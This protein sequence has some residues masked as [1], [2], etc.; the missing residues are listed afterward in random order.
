MA[1]TV[2]SP[3]ACPTAQLA[4]S[5]AISVTAVQR[6]VRA[7]LPASTPA[8]VSVALYSTGD[9]TLASGTLSGASATPTGCVYVATLAAGG[10]P[11]AQ[12][13]LIDDDLWGPN[14]V[15]ARLDSLGGNVHVNVSG[16]PASTQT[17]LPPIACP[18]AQLATSGAISVTGVLRSVRVGLPAS[19]PAG[20]SVALYWTEDSAIA[21]GTLPNA[22][23]TPTG[24]V[25]IATLS[26][27]SN[28]HA[29]TMPLTDEQWGPNLVVV[30]LDALGGT[31]YL[32]VSG[33]PGATQTV[34]SPITAPTAQLATSAAISVTGVQS[35]VRVGLP[36]ATPAGVSVALYWTEDG[37]IAPGTLPAASATP[38][39]CVYIATLSA[40]GDPHAQTMPL[41]DEQWGPY[42]V[43]ARLDGLGGTVHVLVSGDSMG[44]G[45][46]TADDSKEQ[47]L[48]G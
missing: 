44:R 10:D 33:D 24:C 26:A 48:L 3:I 29:Q 47:G 27:G 36:A 45:A 30:R 7:G 11:H 6:S 4:R 19:T 46:V 13:V 23:A 9:S 25:Y 35:S 43:L 34:L 5:A 32:D 28:P 41:A 31:V 17:V 37:A 16:D 12:N 22:S 1:Q 20:V 42:L 8:G 40:G 38:T 14:L 2:L 18:T 21:P 15:V 39:G